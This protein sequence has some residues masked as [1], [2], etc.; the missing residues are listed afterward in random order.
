MGFK[1]NMQDMREEITIQRGADI[2]DGRGGFHKGWVDVETVSAKVKDRTIVNRYFMMQENQQD[3]YTF[4]IYYTDSIEVSR[5]TLDAVN[6]ILWQGRVFDV[7]T[8]TKAD[9]LEQ[10][11]IVETTEDFPDLG[12]G[13]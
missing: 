7:D 2:P 4:T 5:P 8:V 11:L 6:R 10:F 12:N 1:I 9:N 13:D 3:T